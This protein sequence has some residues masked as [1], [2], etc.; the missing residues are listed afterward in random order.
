MVAKILLFIYLFYHVYL[1]YDEVGK[2]QRGRTVKEKRQP[3]ICKEGDV[4]KER[5]VIGY[6]EQFGTELPVKVIS[7]P[8]FEQWAS[9]FNP[10]CLIKVH[11]LG[12]MR[13]LHV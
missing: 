12:R 2:F 3:P 11:Y 13:W 4:I 6:V 1:H 5:Q 7:K 8:S 9:L 10:V